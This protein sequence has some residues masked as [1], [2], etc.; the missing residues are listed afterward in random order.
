MEGE[1]T[2]VCACHHMDKTGL[3]FLNL[4]HSLRLQITE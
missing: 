4:Q 2:S 3:I 1:W